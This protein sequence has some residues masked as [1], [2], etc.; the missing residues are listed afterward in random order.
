MKTLLLANTALAIL[1]ATA[2]EPGE[3]GWKLDADG[4]IELKDGNPI[5]LD[6]SG[7]E[8]TVDGNTISRLNGE[9]KQHRE[10]KEAAETKLKAFGDLDPEAARKALDTLKNIDAKKLIDAGEVDKVRDSVKAEFTTQL[11][12]KDK[13]LEEIN[14]KYNNL[15][16]SNIF[17]NSEFVRDRVAVPTDMFEASFRNNFKIEDGKV[18]AYDKAGNRIMS[19]KTVGEY[20]DPSEALELLVEAHPQRDVILKANDSNGSGNDGRG[21]TQGGGRRIKRSE[22]DKMSPQD[23]YATSMKA[24]KGELQIVD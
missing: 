20:A 19:K 16:I 11:Q 2:F 9:A 23:Q 5:Y 18:T 8:M 1:H 12:E 3:P 10:A 22:Y 4:K 7:R 13:A 24:G 17:A 15:Q 21:G 6:A 14:S